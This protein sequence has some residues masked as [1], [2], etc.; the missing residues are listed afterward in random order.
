M[1]KN[2]K[3]FFSLLL[4]LILPTFLISES[5]EQSSIDS[6]KI[7]NTTLSDE[8]LLVDNYT[9]LSY[10]FGGINTDSSL[11]YS[12]KA[13]D[14]AHKINYQ[15]GLGVGYLYAARGYVQDGNIKSAINNFDKAI[16]IF[17]KQKDT[18]NMLDCYRGMSYVASYSASKLRSLEYNLKALS[19]AEALKDTISLSIIYNNLGTIY[20]KLED[21]ESSLPYFEKALEIELQNNIPQSLAISYSNIGTVNLKMNNYEGAT[22]NYNNLLHILPKIEFDYILAYMNL[23]LS[24]Y[25]NTMGKYDSTEYFLNIAE[26]ICDKSSYK[27]IQTRVY[28][29]FGELRFN[30]KR[31][32]KSIDYFNKSLKLSNEL[33]IS[34]DFPEIF[35]MEA[36]AYAKLGR[37]NDAYRYSQKAI[38]AIDSLKINRLSDFLEEYEEQKFTNELN[39]KNLELALKDQQN[40]NT[41]LRMQLRYKLA[42][43]IIALLIAIVL[44]IIFFLLRSKNKNNRLNIQHEIINNQNLQLEANFEKLKIN[45]S[46]LLKLNAAK[47]KFFS[48]IAH[49]LKSPFSA[50]IGFSDILSNEYNNLDNSKR[51]HMINTISKSAKSTFK[52]LEN[53]LTWARSQNDNINLVHEPTN[54]KQLIANGLDP[55]RSAATAKNITVSENIDSDIN[56]F[57]DSQSIN[58]VISNL[59]NNA[60]KFSTQ[61]GAINITGKIKN[62]VA[63]L[64]ISDN[65]IG[66]SPEIREG[67][68]SIEK[69]V[70]RLGTLNEK[71]TGL[72]L[73]LCKEFIEKNNGT[74]RVESTEGKGSSFY[75]ELPLSK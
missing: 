53:L 5:T 13:I 50:I 12:K 70:Q 58:I 10:L 55:N 61:N 4:V 49:D 8:I 54:L 71:G 42:V 23:S 60:I 69:D 67:L 9:M 18:V 41:E 31:Y 26:D 56:V 6:I 37:Y 45:E 2:H 30:Q 22:N 52:L 44:L 39:Q 28:K 66:M 47:D 75:V 3:I 34:E 17:K 59:F 14:I 33:E 48:I 24:R 64:C 1:H 27:H 65:G 43:Y 74:I 63:E 32:S 7:V 36:K 38:T 46:S 68:F 51:L 19:L 11:L 40:I 25:Y 57:I 35:K 15:K 29:Q 21:F 72:G 62:Q 73:L 16:V 20:L